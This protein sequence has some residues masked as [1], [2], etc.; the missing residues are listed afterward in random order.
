MKPINVLWMG[1]E[2]SFQRFH[3]LDMK[4]FGVEPNARAERE[5]ED[6]YD[7]EF[8]S[9]ADR[10]GLPLLERIGSTA[11]IKVHGSLVSTY[12][13]WHDF[14]IGDITSYEAINDAIEIAVKAEGITKIVLDT[15]T[16]GGHVRGIEGVSRK[17]KWAKGFVTVEAHTDSHAFSAGYWIASSASRITAS[18]MA[19]LGSI[20]TL[21]ITYS[22]ARAAEKD[23]VDYHV[24]RAGEFKALG[25]PYEVLSETAKE[26]LQ[27]NLEKS[28][29]FFLEH[30]SQSRQ[31]SL[32]SKSVWAEGKT[33][34]AEEALSVGLID[35]VADLDEVLGSGA[36]QTSTS[37]NRRFD[38]NIPA[39]KLA[40]IT[41]GADPKD[42]LT[43]EELQFYTA[44]LEEDTTV[45]EESEADAD[46]VEDPVVSASETADLL[47]LAKQIGQLEAQLEAANGRNEKLE[48]KLADKDSELTGLA[49]VAKV[50]VANLCGALGKPKEVPTSASAIVAKFTELQGEMSARFPVGQKTQTN[51]ED[52]EVVHRASTGSFRH[53]V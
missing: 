7:V 43:E 29:T 8:G 30:V 10:I 22:I 42:V 40:Q 51:I 36:S 2:E 3:G 12:R 45:A 47:A 6:L 20:G 16:G 1:T 50:A 39:E 23:G 32:S 14:Y 9:R 27:A 34:F 21:M 25:T 13:W 49:E 48:A 35:Q 33:F 24:F 28:N 19:E 4:Y 17:L 5:D 31:L 18:R 26:S 38:M 46:E 44:Q 53:N 37:D 15:A 52:P 11:V 41:A